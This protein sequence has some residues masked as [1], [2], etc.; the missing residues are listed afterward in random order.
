MRRKSDVEMKR[1]AIEKII[2]T[3]I[4]L[5]HSLKADMELNEKLTDV[6][7]AFDERVLKGQMPKLELAVSDLL[8]EL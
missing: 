8:K 7:E 5:K 6:L 4:R 1:K 2:R 3:N